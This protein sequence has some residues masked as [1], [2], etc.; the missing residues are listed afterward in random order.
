M[1]PAQAPPHDRSA[2]FV[3]VSVRAV[4]RLPDHDGIAIQLAVPIGWSVFGAGSDDGVPL[5]VS[6]VPAHSVAA[7]R[8]PSGPLTDGAW[9]EVAW[10]ESGVPTEL[11]LRYQLCGGDLCLR[12]AELRVPLDD[13]G[14]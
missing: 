9:I 7:A 3:A 2:G 6:A 10:A 12:P 8:I 1:T 5:A 11:S 13:A 14:V 4:R